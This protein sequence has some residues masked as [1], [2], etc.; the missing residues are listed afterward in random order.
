MAIKPK[1]SVIVA[2]WIWVSRMRSLGRDYTFY[3]YSNA[4]G[5][6]VVA[7][8]SPIKQLFARINGLIFCHAESST[9]KV[10]LM[11]RVL[12]RKACIALLLG[13]SFSF[14]LYAYTG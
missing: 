7:S 10:F 3:P 8:D 14:E 2:D 4:T 5:A 6:L 1:Q 9:H 12:A 11:L 13:Q